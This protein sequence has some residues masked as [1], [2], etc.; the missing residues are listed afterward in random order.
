[1]TIEWK[2]WLLG[3]VVGWVILSL[4]SVLIAYIRCWT[5]ERRQEKQEKKR[6]GKLWLGGIDRTSRRAGW[7]LNKRLSDDLYGEGG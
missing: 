7:S 1:M 4:G 6:L 2:S 3:V 5:Y